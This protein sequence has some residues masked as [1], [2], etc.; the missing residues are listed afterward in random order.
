[1]PLG[2]PQKHPKNDILEGEKT[3][4]GKAWEN[5]KFESWDEAFRALAP[6]I[7]QQSVRVAD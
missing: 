2:V 4:N 5:T 6:V 1:M 7:R 3:V